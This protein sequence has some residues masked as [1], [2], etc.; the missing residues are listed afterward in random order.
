MHLKLFNP[1]TCKQFKKTTSDSIWGRARKNWNK[2]H[3][4]HLRDRKGLKTSPC[5]D[6]GQ[7]LSVQPGSPKAADYRFWQL[8]ASSCRSPRSPLLGGEGLE[9]KKRFNRR[10]MLQ[11]PLWPH[12]QKRKIKIACL[13]KCVC[14]KCEFAHRVLVVLSWFLM[15]L[16]LNAKEVFAETWSAILQL[17][18][19][20]SWL[21]C[22]GR[23]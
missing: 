6:Y 19:P 16:C 5:L 3:C 10:E 9:R 7:V 13:V 8:W 15:L 11:L 17:L 4:C 18:L 21:F 23:Q 2:V 1:L 12:R 22:C 20:P 14:P